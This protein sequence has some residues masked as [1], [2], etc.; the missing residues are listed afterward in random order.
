LVTPAC[1]MSRVAAEGA[2]DV[3]RGEVVFR[4]G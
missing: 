2:Q 1:S 3:V 4:F